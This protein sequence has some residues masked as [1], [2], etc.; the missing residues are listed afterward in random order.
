MCSKQKKF[1]KFSTDRISG[2]RV[3]YVTGI[4]KDLVSRPPSSHILTMAGLSYHYVLTAIFLLS[5][6]TSAYHINTGIRSYPYHSS[7]MKASTDESS[8]EKN[9]KPGGALSSKIY[10]TLDPCVTLMDGLV[11]QY[12]D[13]WK[14]KGGIYSLAQGI[15]Y[16]K[17]PPSVRTAIIQALDDEDSNLHIYGPNNG[18]PELT[19]VLQEKIR[20]E[21]HLLNHHIMVT[22]GANQAYVNSV[23]TLLDDTK[24]AVVYRPFY[25]N[26]VM[27]L[28]MCGVDIL[29]GP[30]HDGIPDVDW[31][32]QQLQ[33]DPSIHVVTL[34]NPCNP[35]GTFYDRKLLQRVVDLTRQYNCFLI[36]DCT[37]EYFVHDSDELI[38]CFPDPHVLHIFSLS[39]SHGLAG[40]R[41]GYLAIPKDS[42]ILE[43]MAK[44]QD[45]IPI[46]A[47]RIAQVAGLAAVKEGREWVDAQIATLDTSRRAVMDAL[48]A[49]CGAVIGGSGSMY[50]MGE[51]WTE[52]DEEVARRLVREFGIAVIPGSY[53]G[54]PGWIRV[55]YSNLPPEKCILAAE[56]LRR[57]LEALKNE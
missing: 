56:R 42:T 49:N 4:T 27:S 33:A 3:T 31:L 24:K 20:K 38:A 34:T 25:F 17:P 15:V 21:N 57:G 29:Y 8:D 10:Q 2:H 47:S 53:C 45:C 18:L 22:C 35:T 11:S 48:S 46:G 37:Y 23:L 5:G 19:S 30:S 55:C 1:E 9:S 13:E 44:V 51:L 50:L 41:C 26:H 28:Q 52:N 14:D 39:K 12:V 6:C 54:E 16:W 43:Q 36:L 7:A 40:Y 32:E